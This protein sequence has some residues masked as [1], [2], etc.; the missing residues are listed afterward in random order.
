M[1]P[2]GCGYR[3]LAALA[4]SLA[5]LGLA[6]CGSNSPAAV[7]G[8][9]TFNGAPIDNGSIGFTPI[10]GAKPGEGTVGGAIHDGKYAIPAESGPKPGKYKVEIHWFKA[11]PKGKSG[12][13]DMG[14]GATT[15]GLP[16]KYNTAT[17]LTADIKSGK[18]NKPFDL[19]P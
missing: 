9:V 16:A 5:I 19:K 6:G 1:I 14:Q 8:T 11:G 3:I 17:E 18:N 4:L 10:E 12:D 15:E 13:A 7:E 2:C